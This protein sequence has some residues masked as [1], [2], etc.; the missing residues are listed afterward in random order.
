MY[1][2]NKNSLGLKSSGK[3]SG[4]NIPSC[5]ENNSAL[6]RKQIKFRYRKVVVNSVKPQDIFYLL[7]HLACSFLALLY[8]FFLFLAW[9][10]IVVKWF[11]LW[12]IGNDPER[13][14]A[15]SIQARH[16]RDDISF[17]IFFCL[18]SHLSILTRFGY[19]YNQVLLRWV[20]IREEGPQR[21]FRDGS[22]KPVESKTRY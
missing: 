13:P 12:R 7:F 14:A 5:G 21:I 6:T 20:T 17:G 1:L 15:T 3:T 8:F 16:N 4:S 22:Y 19:N 11:R 18:L 9:V 2:E 10:T